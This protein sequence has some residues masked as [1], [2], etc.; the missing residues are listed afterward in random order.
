M[1]A[2]IRRKPYPTDVSDEEWMYLKACLPTA[3]PYGRPRL[4]GPREILDAIFYIFKSGCAW[5]LLPHDFPPWKTV[6]HYFRTWRLDGTWERMHQVVRERLRVRL[7]RNPQPSAGVVDSQ[8]VK[9]TDV[10]GEERGYDG[11]KKIKGRKRHLLVDT[12]GLVLGA[13]V[14]SAGVADRD[15]IESL[16][17]RAQDRFPRLSHLWLDGGYKGKRKEWI[18]KALG[19]TVE[20]VQHPPKM[21]PQEVMREWAKELAKEGVAIH[22]QMLLPSKGFRVLPRRWVVERTFSWLGQNRR[23]SKDYERLPGTSEAFIY[24]GMTR[25]MVRRLARV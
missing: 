9:T 11:G 24:V 17:E 13:K 23:M 1:L 12:Q 21:A 8:S 22:W 14:H 7:G 16:L 19:W 10:G 4:H 2:P 3:K 25:L 15:G 5:R 6:F 18:E 20:V